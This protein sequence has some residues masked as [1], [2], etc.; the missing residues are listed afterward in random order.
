MELGRDS[1]TG[2]QVK[3][4]NCSRPFVVGVFMPKC[5]L[6]SCLKARFLVNEFH[7]QPKV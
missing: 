4:T 1:D 5:N 2:G 3:L 7:D 6:N